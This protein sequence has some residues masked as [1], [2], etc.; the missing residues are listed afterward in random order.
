MCKFRSALEWLELLR[1]AL[2]LFEFFGF[3]IPHLV[4]CSA[5]RL[6]RPCQDHHQDAEQIQ[7]AA[8]LSPSSRSNGY[9]G[10]PVTRDAPSK[11]HMSVDRLLK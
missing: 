6:P 8:F 7:E 11:R 2:M 1:D 10:D 4:G 5:G 3:R 9:G